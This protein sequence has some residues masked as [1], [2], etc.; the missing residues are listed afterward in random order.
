[1]TGASSVDLY[2][3]PFDFGIDDKGGMDPEKLARAFA[4]AG[5]APVAIMRELIW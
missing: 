3:D 2:Y 4:E 1:M 5:A